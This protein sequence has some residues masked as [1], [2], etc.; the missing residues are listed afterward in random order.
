VRFHET[1]PRPSHATHTGTGFQHTPMQCRPTQAFMA[2]TVYI[3]E[4]TFVHTQWG[5]RGI[6][7]G[8]SYYTIPLYYY[9]L[10]RLAILICVHFVRLF[11]EWLW[12]TI[13][14]RIIV[15]I[16]YMLPLYKRFEPAL[17][18]SMCQVITISIEVHKLR[19]VIC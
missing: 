13:H 18:Y 7:K 10:Y 12:N 8:Y 6:R 14:T 15:R 9:I 3:C 16:T 17:Y 4:F 19:S 1:S 11:I 5:D 2:H